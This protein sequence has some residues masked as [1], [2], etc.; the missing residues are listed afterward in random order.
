MSEMKYIYL[1]IGVIRIVYGG[2]RALV[3][4]RRQKQDRED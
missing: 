3:L 4:V 1:A 2:I